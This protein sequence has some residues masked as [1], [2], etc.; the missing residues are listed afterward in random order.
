MSHRAPP[1]PEGSPDIRALIDTSALRHNLR[2]LRSHAPQARF[3]TVVK[4]NAYGHGLVEIAK[5][6]EGEALA[7]ARLE[8]G[9]ALREAGIARPILLLEGITCLQALQAAIAHRFELVIH[10][11]SQLPLLA[12]PADLT[13]WIKI[14]TGMNRLGFRPEDFPAV[15]ER[16]QQAGPKAI[17]L[18]SHLACA[19]E[20]DSPL[21][22]AQL[23]QFTHSTQ[24]LPY[25]R[26][27][28]A[29][30]GLLRGLAQEEWVRPGI[31]HY[32]VSPFAHRTAADF[33]LRPV[34]TLTSSIIALRE[35][36]TGETVGYGA[37]WRAQRSS[38]VA[39]IAAGYADGLLRS[40]PS[41]TPVLIAGRRAPLVG[42]V[43]MDMCAV[44]VTD[45]PPIHVGERVT[46]WGDG[47]PVEEIAK[48][49]GTIPWELLCAVSGRVPRVLR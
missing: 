10:D 2:V 3:A 15:L 1:A 23:T 18:M 37:T 46:L 13:L 26:S 42:R 7:V 32:G 48:Y 24:G 27:I 30:A 31:A 14:D 11:S 8:E 22:A 17:R 40:L 36:K 34:M 33:K 9:I 12:H 19:D 29:S 16:I 5:A 25:E 44:D 41:G 47:L 35:V 28:C 21:T 20:E 4:A 43:S 49:A 6:G 38:R 39:I 45:L